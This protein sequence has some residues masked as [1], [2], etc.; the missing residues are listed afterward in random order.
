M[1]S[2][3][4]KS[5]NFEN[6]TSTRTLLP[7]TSTMTAVVPLVEKGRGLFRSKMSV[8]LLFLDKVKKLLESERT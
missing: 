4:Q 3:I 1:S 6:E 2:P 8:L 7:S 5:I